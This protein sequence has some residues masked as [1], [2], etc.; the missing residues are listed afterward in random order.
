MTFSTLKTNVRSQ[1]FP[2]GVPENLSTVIDNYIV[3][4]LVHLQKYVPCFQQLNVT[5]T[6]VMTGN[7][8]NMSEY[9][10]TSVVAA[11]D[12][13]INRLYTIDSDSDNTN[14]SSKFDERHYKQK[15][16]KDITEWIKAH[17]GVDDLTVSKTA[18]ASSS[19]TDPTN[20]QDG[21]QTTSDTEAR[22]WTGMWAKYRGKLYI[23]PRLIDS[24]SLVIE[25]TGFKKSWSDG[26]TIDG[27]DPEVQRAVRL[28][29][30][31][32]H[33]RD[34][35]HDSESYQFATAEFN[36]TVS[37]MVWECNQKEVI[38]KQIYPDPGRPS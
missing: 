21:S 32:E 30:T 24:E 7:N 9:I 23:A 2:Y 38:G 29:V 12:G 20:V 10:R 31:K 36:D 16:F 34:W 11:P 6:D 19:T 3:E 25:W 14:S 4:A 5:K 35:D 1:V 27:D 37:E 26:D 18:S 28:Y 22:A 13:V 17:E 8:A 33:A 15:S